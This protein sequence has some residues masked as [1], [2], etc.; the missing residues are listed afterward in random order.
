[1][2]IVHTDC[3]KKNT[4][5]IFCAQKLCPEQFL[6]SRNSMCQGHS[7]GLWLQHQFSSYGSLDVARR[8]WPQFPPGSIPP[9]QGSHRAVESERPMQLDPCSMGPG[10]AE[11]DAGPPQAAICGWLRIW[12][13]RP[14]TK[15]GQALLGSARGP[16]SPGPKKKTRAPA[17]KRWRKIPWV[18][19]PRELWQGKGEAFEVGSDWRTATSQKGNR[20]EKWEKTK[21][22]SGKQAQGPE[23]KSLRLVAVSGWGLWPKKE[24]DWD[25]GRSFVHTFHE[26]Q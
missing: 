12:Q 1:M 23:E 19:S 2:K 6:H 15:K 20:R 3:A 26:V 8:L 5:Q 24:L 22:E 21:E 14:Q 17:T 7:L 13:D 10:G 25:Q 9:P 16:D 4:H 11:V 18:P